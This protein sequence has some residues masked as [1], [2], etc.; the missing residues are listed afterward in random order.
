MIQLSKQF[1]E[2][3][4]PIDL[5]AVLPLLCTPYDLSTFEEFNLAKCDVA[6]PQTIHMLSVA[7]N[8]LSAPLCS[9]LY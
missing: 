6:H 5:T 9:V 7:N 2:E 1:G 3:R 8:L 4:L